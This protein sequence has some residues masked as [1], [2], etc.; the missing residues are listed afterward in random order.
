M[1]RLA[2]KFLSLRKTPEH[3]PALVAQIMCEESLGFDRAK[4]EAKRRWRDGE[5]PKFLIKGKKKEVST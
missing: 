1:S 3:F 2:R 5:R 4:G